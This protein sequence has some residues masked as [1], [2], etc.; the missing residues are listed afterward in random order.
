MEDIQEIQEAKSFE[1]QIVKKSSFKKIIIPFLISYIIILFTTYYFSFSIIS[2]YQEISKNYA[3]ICPLN[4]EVCDF[5]P[6]FYPPQE[7]K[8]IGTCAQ[9]YSLHSLNISGKFICISS[10]YQEDFFDMTFYNK[11]NIEF[12]KIDNESWYWSPSKNFN[13]FNSESTESL[14]TNF[15]TLVI[16]ASSFVIFLIFICFLLISKK[17]S[18]T[19]LIVCTFYVFQFCIVMMNYYIMM[20]GQYAYNTDKEYFFNNTNSWTQLDNVSQYSIL[21]TLSL[22]F[23]NIFF[24]ITIIV[25]LI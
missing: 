22:F 6:Y 3:K 25:L 2:P 15:E 13:V 1:K 23:S 4:K 19:I 11:F 24:S 10:S 8:L 12:Q 9:G 17:K 5:Y 14:Q 16:L 21:K 20:N 18:T 7:I